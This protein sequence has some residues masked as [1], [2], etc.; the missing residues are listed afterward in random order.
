MNDNS[1]KTLIV[2]SVVLCLLTFCLALLQP[3]YLGDYFYL[4]ALIFVEVMLVALWGFAKRFFPL[5]IAV[6]LWAGIDIPLSEIWT[7]RRWFV[8]A[9]AAAAGFAIYIRDRR[10]S[11][12]GIHLT[13][14]VCVLSAVI[15]AL[16][17]SFPQ[18][19]VL[20]AL[21]LFLLFAYAAT[22]ARLAVAGREGRFFNGLLFGCEL[23]VWI[24]TISYFIFRYALFGN[25][26][27]LGAIVGVVVI[28][29]LLWGIFVSQQT[30]LYRRRSF[31]FLLA[32]LL[33][34]ASYSRAAIVAAAVTCAVLCICLG[35]YR[36]LF[37]GAGMALLAAI[38]I[39]TFSPL[40]SEE[41]GSLLQFV[42]KG[43]QV[44]GI[45]ASR[46]SVW[47]RTIVSIRQRPWFGSGFGT[48]A[49]D[50]DTA[51]TTSTGFASGE[52]AREHGNS[53]LAILEWVGLLGVVPFYALVLTIAIRTS[54][55]F[56]WLKRTKDPF[57]PAVPIAVV[58][59]AG[60]IHAGFEDW[61]FAVGYYLC[62]FFWSLA[63]VLI[64]IL[65]TAA[66]SFAFSNP[67]FAAQSNV[68]DLAMPG[69]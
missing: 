17:S 3:N 52:A 2:V 61:M 50:Y 15:S 4:G 30:S 45:M 8:L 19:A 67:T 51:S 5:L 36:L 1:S 62:V 66:P 25:P 16:V 56:V 6:F 57:S 13:A 68:L 10:H 48:V 14:L 64:D 49:T 60:L 38:L 20:K 31:S 23:T 26:N 55:V 7:S 37:Q 27:S 28:P 32:V 11:F 18:T 40:R 69:R 46:N 29:V 34:F 65:P 9:I 43:E 59:I 53:Y 39:A 24:T 33:L 12:S 63:F 35:R 21:S 44:G 22:G 58:M 41:S 54:Q 47:D 42:Y